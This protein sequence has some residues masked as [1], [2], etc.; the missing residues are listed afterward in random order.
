MAIIFIVLVALAFIHFVL[1]AI[2]APWLRF[3]L[4]LQL[5]AL[6]DDLRKLKREYGN[7]L[8]DEVFRDLQSSINATI[9]RLNRI[10]LR[11]L[12]IA[13]DAFEH[14]HKLREHAERRE[15]L[16][17]DC[18]ILEVQEIRQRHYNLIGF[19]LAVNSCGW[20]PYFIPILIG[21]IC[22]KG[23]IAQIRKVFA[24]PENEINK[25]APDLLVTPA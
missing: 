12:K 2:L 16:L 10:D 8:S 7:T 14:D 3:E 15:A 6:R 17:R 5:F 9:A 11:L 22:A 21:A 18:P 13:H 24:L 19:A 20:F 25:L 4:R 23:A 1:E